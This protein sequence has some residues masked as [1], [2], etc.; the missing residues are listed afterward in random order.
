MSGAGAAK[1]SGM[2]S[3]LRGTKAEVTEAKK[4]IQ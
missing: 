3:K 2:M 4:K 1:R